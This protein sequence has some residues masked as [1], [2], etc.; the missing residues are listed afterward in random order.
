MK[1]WKDKVGPS[2]QLTESSFA[3]GG[4]I[5]P[6][7]SKPFYGSY[8]TSSVAQSNISCAEVNVS[9]TNSSGI[10]DCNITE[11]YDS[12]TC[13]LVN[14]YFNMSN[15]TVLLSSVDNHPRDLQF[16]WVYWIS[17]ILLLPTLTAYIYFA[18]RYDLRK[19]E[20]KEKNDD[21]ELIESKE[22]EKKKFIPD[23]N[24]AKLTE[25]MPLLYKLSAF[26]IL[27][28]FMA[29]YYGGVI[30]YGSVSFTY[31]VKSHLNFSKTKAADLTA[32][33]WVA[34][35]MLGIIVAFLQLKLPP[36][37]IMVS[38][39]LFTLAGAILLFI[40]PYNDIS[41]W[42][43]AMSFGFGA[44]TNYPSVLTWINLHFPVSAKSVAVPTAGVNFGDVS[45][46]A[47]VGVLIGSVGPIWFVYCIFI[48]MVLA[49]ILMVVLLLLTCIYEKC[50]ACST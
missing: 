13:C 48:L 46:P 26:V 6:L 42:I 17:S 47:I 22:R 33:Y 28:L 35:V 9:D 29:I 4:L 14:S 19:F 44:A 32:V 12:D 45:M 11:V 2:L 25:N 30:S 36:V 1:L 49:V 41:C 39:V 34:F 7:L 16:G 50:Y 23:K 38:S 31:A 40:L 24:S 37:P 43:V 27:F 5:A 3:I 20:D 10:L 15:S 8:S 21:Y 18:I